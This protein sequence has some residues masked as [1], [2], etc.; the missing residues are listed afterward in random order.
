[1]IEGVGGGVVEEERWIRT[2]VYP[3]KTSVLNVTYC[4]EK[5][6]V[7]DLFLYIND[8]ECTNFR[9]GKHIV[10]EWYLS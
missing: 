3:E 4:R 5:L 9:L 10:F 8:F 2:H 7:L 1:M 6:C